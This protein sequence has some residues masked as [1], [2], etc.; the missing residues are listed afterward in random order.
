MSALGASNTSTIATQLRNSSAG[1][2][3]QACAQGIPGLGKMV[4]GFRLPKVVVVGDVRTGKTCL[5][6]AITRSCILPVH[7][8]TKLPIRLQFTQVQPECTGSIRL[9]FQGKTQTFL[10]EHDVATELSDVMAKHDDIISDE[11][12]ISICQVVML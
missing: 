5:L 3:L 12:C 6:E 1:Q 2:L 11:V 10:S 7:L 9:T 8:P 4:R